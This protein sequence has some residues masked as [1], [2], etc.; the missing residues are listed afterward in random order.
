MAISVCPFSR[1]RS[2]T[3]TQSPLGQSGADAGQLDD[4]V[5]RGVTG[6]EDD[7]G[8][9]H[10]QR[11]RD[12]TQHGVVRT[13]VLGRRRDAHAPRVAVAADDLGPSR[14]G[15]DAQAQ[16]SRNRRHAA[17][18]TGAGRPRSGTPPSSCSSMCAAPGHGSVRLVDDRE[19]RAQLLADATRL[20]DQPLVL[21]ERAPGDGAGLRMR[22]GEDDF[23]LTARLFLQLGRRTLSRDEGRAQQRLE[24]AEAYDVALER[25]DLVGEIRTLAPHV[26]EARCDLQQ[27]PFD[28][29]PL[30]A[31]EPL[32][33]VQM[34][35]LHGCQCHRV[36]PS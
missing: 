16:A 26:L 21:G 8:A 33:Q 1:A 25:L 32:R 4:L 35:D 15:A 22:L 30:V 36:S 23:D 2:C 9:R 14:A 6:D 27:R 5:S 19:R 3:P 24:L 18:C 31:E 28:R 12:Q 20:C 10:G 29:V 17:Q 13:T 7:V 11:V 34:S